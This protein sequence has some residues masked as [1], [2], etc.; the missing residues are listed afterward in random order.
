[1]VYLVSR[2]Q[3]P[4]LFIEFSVPVTGIKIVCIDTEVSYLLI[5]TDHKTQRNEI[6]VCQA[7]AKSNRFLGLK[8]EKK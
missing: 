6:F 4:E 3:L 2:R 8:K 1:M 5:Y 7:Y